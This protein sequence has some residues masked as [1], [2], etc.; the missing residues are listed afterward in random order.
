MKAQTQI[1]KPGLAFLRAAAIGCLIIILA[2]AQASATPPDNPLGQQGLNGE[3]QDTRF[4]AAG[5]LVVK[6]VVHDS[7][8]ISFVNDDYGT[9]VLRYLYQLRSYLL[10]TDYEGDLEALAAEI[11]EDTLVESAQPNYLVDPLQPVQ[12]SFPFSDE[13]NEGS[14]DD[15]FASQTL[16]L[17]TAHTMSQGAEV[18]VAVIDGGVDFDHPVFVG[19]VESGWD[20]IDE[21][22]YSYD[23]PGGDNSGHGTFVAGVVH[24]VA[25]EA[26]IRAYR[27]TEISGES[28]GYIVAEAIMQAVQDGCQVINLSM[29]LTAEHHIIADAI[30]FARDRDVTVVA[31]AGNG[32]SDIPVYPASDPNVLAVAALDDQNILADLSRYGNHVDLCAP[33]IDVYCPYQ[34]DGFAWW[35]G[36]SF[37]AP[38]VAGQAAL[39]VSRT[40]GREPSWI[41]VRNLVKSTA[42]DLDIV[43]PDYIG[44]LGAGLIDPVAALRT[45]PQVDT[46]W[47][48][49][50]EHF[51]QVP[52][53]DSL[54]LEAKVGVFSTNAPAKFF[55]S[56]LDEP[57]FVR[58]LTDSGYT[59]D[60]LVFIYDSGGLPVGNYV[61]T[62]LIQ[63]EGVDNGPFL[64]VA[65]L[66][67][68]PNS[69]LETYV[70]PDTLHFQ[71]VEGATYAVMLEDCAYLLSKNAPEP[72]YAWVNDN[73]YLFTYIQDSVGL[74]GD[75]VCVLVN[76]S[77]HMVG[78]Y[79]N[80]VV[81]WVE[82]AADSIAVLTVCLEVTPNP[83][84]DSAWLMLPADLHFEI[85][86]ATEI[87]YSE[88]AGIYST[89]GPAAY[90][91]SIP[92]GAKFTTLL[93]PTGMTLPPGSHA[94]QQFTFT[95]EA[96]DLPQG[97]YA[98]TVVVEVEGVPGRNYFILTLTVTDPTASD[99]AWV[100]HGDLNFT[101][102][103]GTYDSTYTAVS[104]L[105]SNAP[106][107]YTVNYS[108]SDVVYFTN[109]HFAYPINSSGLT[110]DSIGFLIL[111]GDLA[112]GVHVDTL[113]FDVEGVAHDPFA[114]F[115][116]TVTGD[117]PTTDSAWVQHGDLSY[118]LEEK[119]F[120]FASGS[121]SLF[122]SNAP[123]AYT[124]SFP[125]DYT[126]SPISPLFTT[127]QNNSG[128]TN[129]SV[130]FS[131][132][133]GALSPGTY[134]DT[135]IFEVV[136]VPGFE[137]AV[138]TLTVTPMPGGGDSA[139]VYPDTLV[140]DIPFGSPDTMYACFYLGSTNAPAPFT[141]WVDDTMMI[142][143]WFTQVTGF[144]GDTVC[145]TVPTANVFG[146]VLCD[147]VLFYVEGVA[148]PI[149]QI[150]CT[151]K[152]MGSDT[153][154]APGL[155]VNQNYPNPFNPDTRI[156]FSLGKASRVQ[157]T[158]YNVLGQKVVTLLDDHMPAGPHDVSWSGTDANGNGVAGGIYFYRI[159][160]VD[161]NETR[162]MVYLK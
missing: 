82:S 156:S 112:P 70:T 71:A 78:T 9:E 146:G 107:A 16:N 73:P 76:P 104:L 161:Y 119:S 38:F 35:G 124:V 142:G 93:N 128:T 53:W 68:V 87:I 129:D 51:L 145:Y 54:F 134:R 47:I 30:A 133:V 88:S 83:V 3:E 2:S 60:S 50:T 62:L 103:A 42:Q 144:T 160:T 132:T 86:E 55:V 11:E 79:Y 80:E 37:A 21:D 24:L 63:I 58:I 114:V 14:Y 121:V 125:P 120:G 113:V 40:P 122:S 81:Y 67:V 126:G 151:N 152:E 155:A 154:P 100:T 17:P 4:Y 65:T 85:G 6:L 15:Q 110:P 52:E 123:A 41:E 138:I 162:K 130:N 8:S 69:T 18:T 10:T 31:A 98:D 141:A 64:S 148:E 99:S 20:Y 45:F 105:S 118:T 147:P 127:L 33:G 74:T 153:L 25:P 92:G 91:G 115:T 109:P 150:V 43:N 12:G 96:G 34:N 97:F 1:L 135:L 143:T 94:P 101:L 27:V 77:G 57:N 131:V 29:A 44:K 48:S 59:D 106:A 19:T 75:S 26:A 39:I 149:V 32:Q 157:V 139:W 116:L 46:G 95:V 7:T 28:H 23:E 117:T 108:D 159:S 84:T 5:E 13:H 140:I 89:N 102:P 158:V 61:D 136:G 56:L 111:V 49:P 72:Y 137:Y 36:T 90:T 66:S 22:N